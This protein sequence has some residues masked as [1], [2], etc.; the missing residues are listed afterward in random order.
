MRKITYLFSAAALCLS[1]LSAVAQLIFPADG[2]NKKASVSERI[3]ITDVT[4][5]YDRP[6][7]KGREGKVWGELV[8]YGYKDLGFGSSKESPWRA[9]ANEN[10]T[11]TFSTDVNVEGKPLAAGTYG[12]MMGVQENDVTVIFSKNATSWGSYFYDPKEDALR[13]SVKPLKNQPSVERLKYEFMNETDS[14]A[15]IALLWEKWT[16][17]FTVSVNLVQTQLASLRNELRSEKGFRWDAYQQ[18]ANYVADHKTNLEEGLRWADYSINGQF[19]GE[20]NFSTLQ[21]KAR[22]LAML[23]RTAEAD[24]L[25]K[26]AL[27]MAN[28]QQ[29]YQY[30]RQLINQ[31]KGKEALT[32]F[33]DYA[34]KYPNVFTANM[35]LMRAYSAV[36]DYKSATDWGKKALAV[37]PD[38]NNKANVER[39]L[40]QLQQG[41]DVN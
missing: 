14:S 41:K 35:G 37:A 21:T 10:T 16:I 18:A 20:K 24:A 11:I 1:S 15:V 13:V 29:G 22:L 33:Q 9:G 36:G 6:A 27:P 8:H 19:V 26:E 31:K 4:I 12:L 5:H 23:N 34:K 39:L 2:G 40:G 32:F 25:M 38:N 17:P 7:V 28:M 3:G 30:G